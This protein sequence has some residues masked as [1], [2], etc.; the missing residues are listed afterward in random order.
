MQVHRIQNNNNYNTAFGERLIFDKKLIS[1]ATKEEKAEFV[2][3]KNLFKSRGI[4]GNIEVK[5]DAKTTVKSIIDDLYSRFDK[6]NSE[7][8]KL[9][10]IED[11]FGDSRLI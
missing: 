6:S 10:K 2:Y 7:R 8:I 4:D 11:A 1:R 9:R 5:N 3:L